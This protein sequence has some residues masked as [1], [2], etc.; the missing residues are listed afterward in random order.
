MGFYDNIPTKGIKSARMKVALYNLPEAIDKIGNP[1]LAII[2]NVEDFSELQ[3]EGL[4][5]IIPFNIYD[6]YTRLEILLGRKLSG[7]T[8]TLTEASNIVDELYKRGEIQNEQQYRN[9]LKKF[10]TQ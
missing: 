2:E 6:V 4:K 1:T 3:S 10:I 8:N 9:A 7:H 5:I